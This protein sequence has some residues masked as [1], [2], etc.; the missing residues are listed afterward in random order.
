[1]WFERAA[2]ANPE[3]A[4]VETPAG[5]VS[6]AEL[7]ERAQGAR[8]ALAERGVEPG[9]RVAIALPPGVDFAVSLHGCF[10]LGARAQP[11]D[12]RLSPEERRARTRGAALTVEA[13]LPP[14]PAPGG[15][16]QPGPALAGGIATVMHTSGTSASPKRVELTYANWEAAAAGSARAIGLDPGERW[17]CAL[18]LAHVG[19]L[20]IL[21]RSAI[22]GTTAV[23]HERFEVPDVLRALRED[24]ITVVSLVPTMLARLLDSGLERPPALRC[25]LL[26][27]A[28]APPA[29]LERAA[30]AGVPVAQTYGL[31]EACS[32]VTT[33]PPAE[34][35]TAG[36]P[37]PGVRLEIAADGE[38]LVAGPT[39]AP[40]ALAADGRLHTGDQ[41]R[42]D[43]RGRLTVTG[44]K[45]DTIVSG[46]ENV[47][48]AEVEAALLGHPC[49][50]DAGV[51][52]RRDPDWGEAIVAV[53]VAR[54]PVDEE[55]LRAY[56]R[57]SLASYKV[58][59]A[60]RF[61]EALPRTASGK[62][63]R[64]GLAD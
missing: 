9:D 64:R 21:I 38:I 1:M 11:V 4:A 31:T 12:L 5:R 49:V 14:A 55:A 50:A 52:G 10:V 36:A 63:L 29:L 2:R 41:G 24:G 60:I 6:Y 33:S 48:P 7:G 43:E 39:V 22:Y 54:A 23:V 40:G 42:L 34:A 56:V 59:K 45:A 32:Q 27:G 3:Q 57:T 25:A 20:S 62:L 51:Y 44:R 8:A 37:L 53:V 13:P 58:P 16:G 18:P 61:A 47:A 17:L 28:P 30:A 26:G 19:G 35:E 46:G 15:Q